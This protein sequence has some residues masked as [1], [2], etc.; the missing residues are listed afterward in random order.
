MGAG[1]GNDLGLLDAEVSGS[2]QTRP[3][4]LEG[5]ELVE[6]C[7]NVLEIENRN[8]LFYCFCFASLSLSLSLSLYLT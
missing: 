3:E 1:H 5:S 4:Q 8:V 2:V 6:L 7:E